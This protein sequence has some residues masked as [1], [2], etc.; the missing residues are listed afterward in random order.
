MSD[1]VADCEKLGI[2]RLSR[3][4]SLENREE[5]REL[6][7]NNKYSFD[8]TLDDSRKQWTEYHV[9]N[10]EAEL[11]FYVDILGMKAQSLNQDYAVVHNEPREFYIGFW[12]ASKDKPATPTGS[13]S[14]CFFFENIRNGVAKL[15]DRGVEFTDNIKPFPDEN[16]T[17]R[18]AKLKTPNNHNIEIWGFE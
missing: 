14:I 11:G 6:L 17:C 16:G 8:I 9:D 13:I 10:F 12:R 3:F 5:R 4:C 7:S 18:L 1:F 15:K 2:E